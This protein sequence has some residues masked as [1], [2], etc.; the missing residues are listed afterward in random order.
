MGWILGD[1]MHMSWKL[2]LGLFLVPTVLYGVLAIVEI[3]LMFTLAR[4]GTAELIE[5][6][7]TPDD[8]QAERPFALIY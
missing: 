3:S 7:D 5:S 2:Q 4:R 8:E 6:D 1:E